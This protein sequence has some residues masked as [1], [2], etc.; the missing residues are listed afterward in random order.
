[1]AYIERDI[2][3]R[4]TPFPSSEEGE[5]KEL[6]VLGLQL[7]MSELVYLLVYML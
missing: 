6:D 4:H 7:Q 2:E 1:M 5:G 3:L